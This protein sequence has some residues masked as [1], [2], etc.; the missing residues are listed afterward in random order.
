MLAYIKKKWSSLRFRKTYAQIWLY[1]VVACVSI[2]AVSTLFVYIVSSNII[3]R[4]VGNHTKAQLTNAAQSLSFTMNWNIDFAQRSSANTLVRAYALKS[5]TTS[6]EDYLM[7]LT[8]TDLKENN[9]YIDSIYLVNAYNHTIIDTRFGVSEQEKF[10]DQDFLQLLEQ[11]KQPQMA[12]ETIVPRLLKSDYITRQ[13]TR[14]ISIL[15]PFE[16][17]TFGSIFV[18]N[19]NSD[20]LMINNSKPKSSDSSLY[21]LN[22]DQKV[23]SSNRKADFLSS[24]SELGYEVN[25]ADTSGWQELRSPPSPQLVV[26][27]E[28]PL[29]VLGPWLIVE[30]IPKSNLVGDIHKLQ[31]TTFIFSACLLVV[32]VWVIRKFSKKIYS[33]IQELIGAVTASARLKASDSAADSE[34]AYLSTVFLDQNHTIDHFSRNERLLAKEAFLRDLLESDAAKQVA[35]IDQLFSRYSLGIPTVNLLVVIFRIDHFH[36]FCQKYSDR[37]RRLLRFAMMN[38][39]KES[40]VGNRQVEAVDLGRDHIAAILHA[41]SERELETLEQ[42]TVCCQQAIADFLSI[43]TTAAIGP[44]VENVLEIRESYQQARGLSEARFLLG[45]GKTIIDDKAGEPSAAPFQYPEDKEKLLLQAL[46]KGDYMQLSSL[47]DALSA[48]IRGRSSTEARLIVILLLLSIGKTLQQLPIRIEQEPELEWSLPAIEIQVE[49]LETLQA[50]LDWIQPIMA[51]ACEEMAALERTPRSLSMV[52]DIKSIV[53]QNYL[54]QNLSSKLISDQLSLSVN[55][56]RHLFKSETNQSLMD[57]ITDRRMEEVVG[58]MRTT[59]LTI[60]EIVLQSGFTSTISFYPTFKKK[61]GVTPAKYRK[62]MG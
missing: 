59:S 19:L 15:I 25:F 30:L 24:F 55:Y 3:L 29:K 60:D 45:W 8:L 43:S 46:R 42:E 27:G 28:V 6:Y 5:E 32:I 53:E 16:H 54:D 56:V 57:Y 36:P 18:V 1:F 41:A 44:I 49:R 11:R 62:E 50:V 10:Y 37:D 2:L 17:D 33:P 31:V 20:A 61:Y 47:L 48:S 21:V 22:R 34:L 26:H 58:L 40:F 9:P 38:I 14:L 39:V 23:I 4:E 12:A 52:E 7:W 13:E 51:Q 35:S